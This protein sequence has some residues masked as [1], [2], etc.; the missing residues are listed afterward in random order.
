MIEVYVH[1][2]VVG[3]IT[4]THSA[5]KS[6]LLSGIE[7]GKLNDLNVHDTEYDDF[8]YAVIQDDT[9]NKHPLL[10]IPESA[11]WWADIAKHADFLAENYT[12]DFQIAVDSHVVS[13]IHNAMHLARTVTSAL[14]DRDGIPSSQPIVRPVI[15][16]DRGPL[17]GIVYSAL[18]L[19]D[20][21][22]NVIN[23]SPRTGFMAE[24]L[25][26]YV[27]LVIVA[28]HAGVPVEID[29]ARLNDV[30]FRSNVATLIER[31]YK[32]ILGEE[33]VATV[34]GNQTSRH[35][36][37]ASLLS[38][39]I[40]SEATAARNNMDYRDWPSIRLEPPTK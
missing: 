8:G 5:G 25:K 7:A 24:W 26:S 27:D 35:M 36:E 23:G 39:L 20:Q 29:P 13:R 21:D 33:S 18:R 2:P 37:L 10:T 12:L 6:T 30:Q 31:S 17:D 14:I 15:L 22:T 9:G 19:P 34:S 16:S 1:D 3:I 4:G 32:Q 38:K 40:S 28:D 11:R